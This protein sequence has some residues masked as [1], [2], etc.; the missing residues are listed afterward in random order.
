MLITIKLFASLRKELFDTATMEFPA[1]TTVSDIIDRLALPKDEITLLF[2]NG[3]HSELTA[4]PQDGDT[5]AIFPA[6]GGG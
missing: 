1:G 5:L 6:V 4:T 2:L 3:R